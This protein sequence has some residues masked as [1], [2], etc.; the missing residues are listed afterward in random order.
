MKQVPVPLQETLHFRAGD[1]IIGQSFGA[2]VGLPPGDSMW[3]DLPEIRPSAQTIAE[4]RLVSINRSDPA[5]ASFDLVRTKVLQSLR[6]NSWTSIAVTSPTPACGKSL[7]SLN[8]AFSLSH[9]KD[10][11]TII[12]DL[13][14]KKPSIAGLLGMPDPPSMEAFLT[15]ASGAHE[16]LRRY[17]EN[18]LIGANKYPVRYSSELL[19]SLETARVLKAMQDKM[20]PDVII[21]DLPPMLSSDDVTA[22]LPCVDCAI[23]VVGAEQSTFEEVDACEREL[24]ER[25]N[26]LGVVLNKCRYSPDY[27]N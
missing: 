19:Q 7:V 17:D 6:Q 12:I 10:C 9:Q 21:Y 2:T 16:T 5:H 24:A 18:L 22:F 23:L 25:T 3:T 8:L 14:L 1:S 20:K 13:N 15:G 27:R 4:N 11:R 26:V